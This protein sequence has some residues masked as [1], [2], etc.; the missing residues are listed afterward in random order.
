[1]R[2]R[3]ARRGR[4]ECSVPPTLSIVRYHPIATA[5]GELK[6]YSKIMEGFQPAV[7]AVGIPLAIDCWGARG[8]VPIITKDCAA[9]E[10][11]LVS[12]PP[13]EIGGEMG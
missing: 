1:L 7:S 10:P 11:L 5:A 2:S 12:I 8:P 4:T 6:T 9:G 3:A 13:A